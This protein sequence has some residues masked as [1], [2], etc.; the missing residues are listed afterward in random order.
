MSSIC[1]LSNSSP[2]IA[3]SL[4]TVWLHV[5]PAPTGL[6]GTGFL[7]SCASTHAGAKATT[8]AI[9]SCAV[10]RA[11]MK[12]PKVRHSGDVIRPNDHRLSQHW[13]KIVGVLS[14]L[15]PAT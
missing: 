10:K 8:P 2:L 5:P 4:F 11:C 6:G 9:A 13:D 15:R 7:A 12:L 3:A 14:V 1:F